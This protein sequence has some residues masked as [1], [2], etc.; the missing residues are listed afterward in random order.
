MKD[1]SRATI[2]VSPYSHRRV[3][4]SN[5]SPVDDYGTIDFQQQA[6]KG[7][8]E[9]HRL[10]ADSELIEEEIQTSAFTL[11]NEEGAALTESPRKIMFVK[12]IRK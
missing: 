8:R 1:Q 7:Q 10:D 12:Q 2:A 9:A 3:T 6:K 4:N 5:E 11:G